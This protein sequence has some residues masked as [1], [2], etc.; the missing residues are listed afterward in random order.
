MS[1]SCIKCKEE[2]EYSARFCPK[3][4]EKIINDTSIKHSVESDVIMQ[5]K[6]GKGEVRYHYAIIKEEVLLI[7]KGK[8]FGSKIDYTKIN[9][10]D[11]INI[12]L[13]IADRNL[14]NIKIETKNMNI[15]IKGF[16]IEDA[17]PF[18][19][20]IKKIISGDKDILNDCVEIEIKTD[21]IPIYPGNINKPYIEYGQIKVRADSSLFSKTATMEDANARLREEAVKFGANAII[22]TKYDRSSTHSWRG[23]KAEGTAIYLESD[24]KKC[25]YCAEIIKIE[26]IKCKHCGFEVKSS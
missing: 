25:P 23:I 22:N 3:C 7:G 26:A 15:E 1:K 21:E 4:G 17:A 13:N 12:G 8:V 11:I 9:H 24:E 10:E 18:V 16:E 19:R 5:I 14:A 6:G 20:S 2:V